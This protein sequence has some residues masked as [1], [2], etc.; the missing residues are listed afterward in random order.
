MLREGVRR[1]GD[2]AGC[3]RGRRG[4][5]DDRPRAGPRHRR[6]ADAGQRRRGVRVRAGRQRRLGTGPGDRARRCRQCRPLRY[7][8]R[9]RSRARP[10]VRRCAVWHAHRFGGSSP[11]G[12]VVVA[13]R[14]CLFTSCGW[15][16]ISEL[17]SLDQPSIGQ[18]A[19]H[20]IAV[21]GDRVFIGPPAYDHA[22]DVDSGR[23]IAFI[24]DDIFADGFD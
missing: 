18:Q 5:I 8:G 14:I 20:A 10:R 4:R 13:Q 7:R 21:V 22:S 23:V 24:A 6:L 19:G 15:A 12:S 2:R 1:C 11:T 17:Y 16:P 9:L 3:T